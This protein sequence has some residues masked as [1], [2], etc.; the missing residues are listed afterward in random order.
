MTKRCRDGIFQV[1]SV[2]IHW[3]RNRGIPSA[4]AGAAAQHCRCAFRSRLTQGIRFHFDM[5]SRAPRRDAF[6][7]LV[8]LVAVQACSPDSGSTA[9]RL[10]TPSFDTSRFVL[11]RTQLAIEGA[12]ITYT[13]TVNNPGSAVSTVSATGFFIQGTTRREAGTVSLSCGLSPG[14]L[15]TGSCTISS[16]AVASNAGSGSGT[17]VPGDANFELE[18]KEGA[19]VV[20]TQSV[21]VAL[22]SLA[23][24]R[25]GL[26]WSLSSPS[27]IL[28]GLPMTYSIAELD[29][30]GLDVSNVRLWAWITQGATR[31]FAGETELVCGADPGVLKH[32]V[33]AGFW[34]PI[35][36]TSAGAGGTLVPGPATFQ[37]QLLVNGTAVDSAYVGTTLVPPR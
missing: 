2:L 10:Q 19:T 12:S 7:I 31:R 26:S 35:T 15:G 29:N 17:L 33:C 8:G 34:S 21:P 9:P 37:L 18:L 28:D 25:I 11:S 5:P 36:A 6:A 32:G 16:S 22:V 1:L 14:V 30:P 3:S 27:I 13:A 23:P 20:S 24:P 4:L